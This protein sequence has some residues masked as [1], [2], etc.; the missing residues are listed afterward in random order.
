M[1]FPWKS[2]YFSIFD[3]AR[4]IP[5][6]FFIAGR[7]ENGPAGR[8]RIRREFGFRIRERESGAISKYRRSNSMKGT[9]K[10]K[11]R[12]FFGNPAGEIFYSF[13]RFSGESLGPAEIPFL[14]QLF[15]GLEGGG[16]GV[17][18]ISRLTAA[19]PLHLGSF[20]KS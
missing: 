19:N 1:L 12:F 11:A 14:T 18:P 4:D 6:D 16:G 8:S 2:F 5:G 10:G 17:G 9:G 13:S 15:T 7:G 3:F 20:R